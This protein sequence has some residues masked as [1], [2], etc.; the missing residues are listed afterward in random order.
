MHVNINIEQLSRAT[1][2]AANFFTCDSTRSPIHTKI[3][4]TTLTHSQLSISQTKHAYQEL[5]CL[6]FQRTPFI[7]CASVFPYADILISSANFTH[8][9]TIVINPDQAEHS[10]IF[11]VPETLLKE[12]SEYFKA[13]CRS[14][15]EEASTRI[16]LIPEVDV[17]A[18]KAYVHW[19]YKEEISVSSQ[20]LLG[21]VP[22]IMPEVQPVFAELIQLWLLADRFADA[23]LQQFVTNAMIQAARS[24][25]QAN[26][27]WTEGITPA[28]IALIWSK[29]TPGRALRR[30]VIDFYADEVDAENLERVMD[31]LHPEFVMDLMLKSLRIKHDENHINYF[32]RSVC[33]Y[34]EHDEDLGCERRALGL[35]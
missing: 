7:L 11:T 26:P 3:P 2:S 15:W 19:I 14:E 27:D 24:V 18:F 35:H 12:K 28:M 34:H 9:L 29:T 21:G 4:V 13:Q 23:Q 33:Y 6:T 31:E 32:S 17:S 20:H 25:N 1:H 30:L 16:L 5:Q 8:A 10:A 22:R